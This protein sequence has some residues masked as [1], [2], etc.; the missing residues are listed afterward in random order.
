MESVFTMIEK[1]TKEKKETNKFKISKEISAKVNISN[2]K[3]Q[4]KTL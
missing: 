2:N 1:N 3:V 4:R